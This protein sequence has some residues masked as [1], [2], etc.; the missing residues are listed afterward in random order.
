MMITGAEVRTAR[1]WQE[2]AIIDIMNKPNPK[3][4]KPL[5]DIPKTI[6]KNAVG[7]NLQ[8]TPVYCGGNLAAHKCT[9]TNQ[10]TWDPD[11]TRK[12]FSE[13]CFK[14]INGSWEEFTSMKEERGNAAG[15]VYKNEWHI[16][17]GWTQGPLDA[18]ND[19]EEI[20]SKT[21]EIISPDGSVRKGPDLPTEMSNHAITYVT[22][23]VSIL[24]GGRP[25]DYMR[26]TWYYNHETEKFTSGPRLLED[27]IEHASATIVDK[28]GKK[29]KIPIVAGGQGAGVKLE[30]TEMLIEGQWQ[31][32]TIRHKN[33]LFVLCSLL[34]VC[35]LFR[36][37]RFLLHY[38]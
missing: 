18:N 6:H 23:T 15:I 16:F 28:G 26:S 3:I 7:T 38:L 5:A 33:F 11:C 10:E 31:P 19:S 8:G 9:L 24:S 20:L 37:L 14:F 12:T 25:Y 36:K 4:C 22:E 30:S 17:G 21:S 1:D 27:R 13:K 34:H 2:T 35:L 29:E 32:G